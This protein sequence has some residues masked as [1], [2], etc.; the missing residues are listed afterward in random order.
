MISSTLCGCCPSNAR[1]LM[2]RWTDSAI[3]NHEPLNGVYSAMIPW[4]GH[5]P[6]LACGGPPDCRGSVP[7]ASAVTRPATSPA[8]SAPFATGST[9]HAAL[10]R[11]PREDARVTRSGWRSIRSS[12]SHAS[13]RSGCWSL[14]PRAPARSADGTNSAFARCPVAHVR[15]DSVPAALAVANC[16]LGRARSERARLHLLS[17]PPSPVPHPPCRL[18]QSSFFCCGIGI[19]DEHD[20]GF[21]LAQ[22]GAGGPLRALALPAPGRVP[23]DDPDCIAAD[24]GQASGGAA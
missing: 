6:P 11:S 16:S 23:Q 4:A 18:T 3:F 10:R 1:R 17:R 2:M 14:H 19:V 5:H 9:P 20:P 15:A 21:A 13:P 22:G 12:A 8:G 7:G 24:L